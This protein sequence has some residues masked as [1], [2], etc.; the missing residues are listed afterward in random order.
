VAND[1]VRSY[2][3]SSVVEDSMDNTTDLANLYRD[4]LLDHSKHPRNLRHLVDATGTAVGHNRLC[5]DKLRLFVTLD[6][7]VLRDVAFQGAGCAI[8]TASASMMTEAVK[9]LTLDAAHELFKRFHA[10]LTAPAGEP[11]PEAAELGKLVVF[12]G[13]REY[14]ARVKCAT[15]AWHTLEAALK[16]VQTPVSTE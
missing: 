13:V 12:A 9:G 1:G 2:L 10:L 14:P 5:G 3:R 15:L 11:R 7:G 4:V 16:N 8:S 6:D